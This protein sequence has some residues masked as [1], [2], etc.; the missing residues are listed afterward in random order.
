MF[1][2]SGHCNP[3]SFQVFL[4]KIKVLYLLN[5]ISLVVQFECTE[6]SYINEN[7]LKLTQSLDNVSGEVLTTMKGY[8]QMI[9]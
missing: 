8:S 3:V 5:I 6:S 2:S 7:Q 4:A 9:Y 1:K